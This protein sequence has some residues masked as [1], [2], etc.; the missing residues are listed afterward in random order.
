LE[1]AAPMIMAGR[2]SNDA[3]RVRAQKIREENQMETF[4][5]FPFILS[6]ESNRFKLLGFTIWGVVL[7]RRNFILNYSKLLGNFQKHA[8]GLARF[9]TILQAHTNH[10]TYTSN[11]K[12]SARISTTT[13]SSMSWNSGP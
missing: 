13:P 1:S 2:K 8:Y 3:F 7:P 9:R 12:D 11:F 10:C 6:S 4:L 5:R